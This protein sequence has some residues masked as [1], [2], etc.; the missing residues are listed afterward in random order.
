MEKEEKLKVI[1]LVENFC[2][3]TEADSVTIRQWLNTETCKTWM[4]DHESA[5]MF[6]RGLKNTL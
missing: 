4:F 6:L 3:D 5:P 2:A 1:A